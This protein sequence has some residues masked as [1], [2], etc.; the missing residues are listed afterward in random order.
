SRA[1]SFRQA[2]T[3]SPAGLRAV[4]KLSTR[5]PSGSRKQYID[6]NFVY[7]QPSG[8]GMWNPD[9][10][11]KYDQPGVIDHPSSQVAALGSGRRTAVDGAGPEQDAGEK[12]A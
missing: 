2:V 7:V 11:S 6:P 1:A 8:T 5:Y 12:P 3:G 10:S 4:S 9:P